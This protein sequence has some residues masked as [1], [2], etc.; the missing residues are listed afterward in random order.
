M[1]TNVKDIAKQSHETMSE[2]MTNVPSHMEGSAD[3][4]DELLET[5]T[6]NAMKSMKM[7]AENTFQTQQHKRPNFTKTLSKQ[8][9]QRNM[10]NFTPLAPNSPAPSEYSVISSPSDNITNISEEFFGGTP[11]TPNSMM[12]SDVFGNTSPPMSPQQVDP[13]KLYNAFENSARQSAKDLFA[14]V[15]DPA[16]QQKR[17]VSPPKRKK[18]AT[19]LETCTQLM[20]LSPLLAMGR[21]IEGSAKAKAVHESMHLPCIN[22]DGMNKEALKIRFK[23]DIYEKKM[24]DYIAE[25][26]TKYAVKKKPLVKAPLKVKE[27]KVVRR[28]PSKKKKLKRKKKK[29]DEFNFYSERFRQFKMLLRGEKIDMDRSLINKLKYKDMMLAKNYVKQFSEVDMSQVDWKSMVNQ[30][31]KKVEDEYKTNRQEER[32]GAKRIWFNNFVLQVYNPK[33]K[34]TKRAKKVFAIFQD[35]ILV[36]DE[37][38]NE[39]TFFKVLHTIPSHFLCKVDVQRIVSVIA[40]GFSVN[41]KHFFKHFHDRNIPFEYVDLSDPRSSM[42][43]YLQDSIDVNYDNMFEGEDKPAF[44]FQWPPAK[45]EIYITK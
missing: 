31:H 44:N 4:Q 42:K 32:M 33:Y 11:Q 37:E 2:I 16:H 45:N 30:M 1:K 15:M 17:T 39:Q 8:L 28:V 35:C 20:R 3:T 14:L 12:Q 34:I 19:D 5:P 29:E 41:T 26:E 9:L 27:K 24:K 38:V 40:K 13:K 6:S 22:L 18:R 23:E 36:D 25:R 21:A 43:V 7:W 10:T